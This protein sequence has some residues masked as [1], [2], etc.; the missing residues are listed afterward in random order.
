M[1]L[2]LGLRG[3]G[4]GEDYGC[5]GVSLLQPPLFICTKMIEDAQS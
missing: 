5:R 4:S 3:D 2:T 1:G